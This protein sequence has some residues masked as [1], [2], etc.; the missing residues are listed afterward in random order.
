FLSATAVLCLAACAGDDVP[1]MAGKFT[2]P[3]NLPPTVVPFTLEGDQILVEVEVQGPTQNRKILCALNMG[4]PVSG[5]ME[6]VWKETGHVPHTPAK[7]SVGGIPVEVASGASAG[8]DDAAYPDRQL[9]F[10]FFTHQVEG[11][12]QAGFLEN[13]DI[14][15]DYARKTLTLAAPGTLPQ[16]GV[17]V[18]IRVK[19]ETG[20]ATVDFVVDGKPYPIVIDVGGP[21]SFIRKSVAAEWLQTHPEWRHADGAIGPANYLMI[22][23][24]A[25]EKGS[26][27]RLDKA[28]LGPMAIENAGFFGVGG[29]MGP[30]GVIST[31]AFFDDWQKLAPEP[32]IGWLGANVLKHYRITI[33]YK[34]QMS[35]WKKLSDIDPHELDQVGLSLVYDKGVYSVG[36]IVAKDGKPTAT[37]IEKGDK[38]AAIDD[39]PVKGWSRDQLFAA[40]GGKLGDLHKV[41]V[42]RDGKTQTFSLPVEAF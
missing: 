18:P 11:A 13:F 1:S 33:D 39:A 7:F 8:L 22:G 16:D 21:Y 26:L 12:V 29:G 25:E 17:A 15:L 41:T 42:D 23:Q 20:L 37:G 35:W 9:D 5:W 14:T 6:H 38:L 4:H 31:E 28:T 34:A 30:L 2:V 32:V 27:M 10:W 40:L 24:S 3:S 36:R 19:P